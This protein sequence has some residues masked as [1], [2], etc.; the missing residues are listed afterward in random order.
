MDLYLEKGEI[1]IIHGLLQIFL[2]KR[3]LMPTGQRRVP[4]VW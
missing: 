1:F 3:N 4:T 2:I